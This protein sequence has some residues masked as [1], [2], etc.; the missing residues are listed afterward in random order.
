ME[1][2]L[3]LLIYLFI[4]TGLLFV[5]GCKT[6]SYSISGSWEFQITINDATDFFY[7]DFVGN[8][9]SGNVL[10]D[11]QVYGN[12]SVVGATVSFTLEYND[13]DGDYTVEV[14]NGSFDDDAQMSGILTITIEGYPAIQG[15]WVALR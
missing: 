11:N 10:E 2:K 8:D 6:L 14:Y 4:I 1:S 13:D 12:Y 5:P 9:S 3:K 7:Y 15:E